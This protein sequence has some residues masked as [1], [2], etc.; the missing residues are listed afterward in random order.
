M[1]NF[2]NQDLFENECR[3]LL[4]E[5]DAGDLDERYLIKHA[6][7]YGRTAGADPVS[8]LKTL[9]AHVLNLVM[10]LRRRNRSQLEIG[11]SCA[12]PCN[13]QASGTGWQK[14]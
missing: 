8:R 7:D 2:G 14:Q 13:E 1:Q 9:G 6:G 11:P 4:R 5:L 3:D 12:L 10:G